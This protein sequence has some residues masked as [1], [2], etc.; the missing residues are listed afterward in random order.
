MPVVFQVGL[1]CTVL[2]IGGVR[3][4]SSIRVVTRLP[5]GSG[6]PSGIGRE[7]WMH[8]A[9]VWGV[10]LFCGTFLLALAMPS[11]AARVSVSLDSALGGGAPVPGL[12]ERSD[13][14]PA[15]QGASGAAEPRA[16]DRLAAARDA[17][18]SEMRVGLVIV[19]SCAGG[20]IAAVF[21]AG[22]AQ[23]R[24]RPRLMVGATFAGL[25]VSVAGF[26]LSGPA[27]SRLSGSL[28]A[29]RAIES[30][31]VAEE[32]YA[33]VAASPAGPVKLL[34]R[35]EPLASGNAYIFLARPDSS[36]GR[37]PLSA[38]ESFQLAGM[39][40]PARGPDVL[41]I[42]RPRVRLGA[43]GRE[44]FIRADEDVMVFG[45]AAAG[46]IVPDP[47]FP[48]VVAPGDAPRVLQEISAD[49]LGT[50]RPRALLV[51]LLQVAFASGAGWAMALLLSSATEH[52]LAGRARGIRLRAA[53]AGGAES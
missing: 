51:A 36:D 24:R 17:R 7:R 4:L 41:R 45:F 6:A 20:A 31:A 3:L 11:R 18:R 34:G 9:V 38:I 28:Q 37:T 1:F 5:A 46:S 10:V 44:R 47:A 2:V 53:A 22:V 30:Y 43:R 26:V 27:A 15:A 39:S 8:L 25:V 16:N 14:V 21:G 33:G 42:A 48:A 13:A 35:P 19:V 32:V 52:L 12:P 23:R 40:V 50:A 49:L 29:R